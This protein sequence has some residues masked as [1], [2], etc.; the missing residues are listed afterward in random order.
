MFI[1][2]EAL[3]ALKMP[4]IAWFDGYLFENPGKISYLGLFIKHGYSSEYPGQS[5]MTFAVFTVEYPGGFQ[6]QVHLEI[7]QI[8]KALKLYN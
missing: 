8:M 7:G 1:P 3:D 5:W 6:D 2:K 4:D